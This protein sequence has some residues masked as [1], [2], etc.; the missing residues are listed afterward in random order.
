MYTKEV[1]TVY[2]HDFPSYGEGKIIPHCIYDIK[3]NKGYMTIGTSKETSAFWCDCFRDWWNKYGKKNY[4]KADEILV[5]VD[6]GG[7]NSSR[8][9]IFKEELQ[10]LVD[11]IGISIRIAHYPPYTSKYNPIEHKVFCHVSRACEGAVFSS[12]EIVKQLMEKTTTK[13]G[14]KLFTQIKDTVYET[15][16]SASEYFKENMEII[17]DSVLGKWNY[18]VVPTI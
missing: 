10:K 8:A 4:P 2:D 17:F 15:G 11:E 9:Y 6:G 14:L 7:S 12:I 18:L 5:L 13:K 16:K 1:I 3:I